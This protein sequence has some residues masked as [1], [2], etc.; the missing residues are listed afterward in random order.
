M[1]ITRV[2]Q[3][4]PD[5]VTCPAVFATDEDTMIVQGRRCPDEVLGML[6]LGAGEFAVEI[7]A[8]VWREA[9]AQCST[10]AT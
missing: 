3:Q 8:E 1:R 2:G 6:R 7:P 4:C 9:A 10:K 5:G